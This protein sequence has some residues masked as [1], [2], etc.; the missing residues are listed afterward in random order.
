[1][2]SKWGWMPSHSMWLASRIARGPKR[3][4][5]RLVTLPSQ[6]MPATPRDRDASFG[7]AFMKAVLDRKAK[8]DI[9]GAPRG[10]CADDTKP[11]VPA[12][13]GAV[14]AEC[15][16]TGSHFTEGGPVS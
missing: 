2:V 6:A 15:T 4:P 9:D 1:M 16:G 3:A 13:V 8:D 12:P 11:P 14:G 10:G 7:G 5:G